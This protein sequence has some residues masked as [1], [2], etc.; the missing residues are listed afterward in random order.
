[1]ASQALQMEP[2]KSKR[3]CNIQTLMT[4]KFQQRQA[5]LGC[6]S[7]TPHGA[8]YGRCCWSQWRLFTSL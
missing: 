4:L 3:T 7:L 5:A 8:G 1:M 2:D 6:S